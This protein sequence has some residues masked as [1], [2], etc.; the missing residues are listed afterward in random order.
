MVPDKTTLHV[1][2]DGITLD[3]ERGTTILTAAR[4]AGVEI[5][6]LCWHPKVSIMGACRVCLVEV[7][8]LN[9]LIAA[10]HTPVAE[11]MVV[12]TATP[13][14]RKLR[15]TLFELLLARHPRDCWGCDKGGWCDLQA[16][17]FK[18]GP[19]RHRFE[20]PS[21]ASRVEDRS[22]FVER[23]TRKCVMC[24]RCIR[25]C[26]EVRGTSVWG[27]MY[28]GFDKKICTFFEFPLGSDFHD[29]FNCEFCGSC[30]DICPVG[31][32]TAKPSKYK[33]RPWEVETA[34][35]SCPFCG[36]GCRMTAHHRRGTLVKTTP[37]K[38]PDGNHSD[39]CFRG[40]FGTIHAAHPSRL[41]ETRMGRDGE[42]KAISPEKAAAAL[43]AVLAAAGTPGAAFVGAQSTEEETAALA[44]LMASGSVHHPVFVL[45]SRGEAEAGEPAWP[46]G[47]R[48]ATVDELATAGR[49][50][51]IGHDFT[52]HH[53][54][55]GVR[56]RK[57]LQAGGS[58]LLVDPLDTLLGRQAAAWLRVPPSSQAALVEQFRDE[59]A[60]ACGASALAG[61][62][63]LVPGGGGEAGGKA[64]EWL[65][66][67]GPLTV[68]IQ[69]IPVQA[70]AVNG[71]A[72]RLLEAAG[73]GSVVYLTPDANAFGASV[74]VRGVGPA[75][76]ERALEDLL[77]SDRRVPAVF[78][79]RADPLGESARPEL[80]EALRRRS[81]TWVVFDSFLTRTAAR[82]DLV[83]PVPLFTE[84]AGSIRAAGGPGS[85][86][87][88][89]QPPPSVRDM[90][91]WAGSAATALGKGLAWDG[92]A[93]GLDD[94]RARGRR[95]GQAPPAPVAPAAICRGGES[96]WLFARF[97]R[98]PGHR[99]ELAEARAV[100]GP[101]ECLEVHPADAGAMGLLDGERVTV[102]ASG[103]SAAFAVRVTPRTPPG[104]L[105]LP[106]DP[107]FGDVI[108]FMSALGPG[109]VS[110]G[111]AVSVR[112]G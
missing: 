14:I 91:S 29:P 75:A 49:I 84:N 66:G 90:L 108:R 67:E 36:V 70:P 110:G 6:T 94:I 17:A 15:Q 105:C 71:A 51:L 63:D 9:K 47:I 54:V 112:K 55:A 77:A 4:E 86:T 42:G 34:E 22:P 13:L 81:T 23:D 74:I 45:D 82:A 102:E 26:R 97:H 107:S 39:L 100:I 25:V 28:R 72:A 88:L 76:D 5:P 16:L 46:S 20:L 85:F 89:Y 62:L 33:T 3:V 58:L 56:I 68:V 57:A 11:G 69:K 109:F 24:R 53:P 101:Q 37:V 32:L 65:K 50:I 78:F 60:S 61:F 73:G 18:F 27:A 44:S 103:A 19:E 43:A 104:C 96:F 92:G 35:T 87:R 80:W 12:R 52:F 2:I 48:S 40:R 95:V 8:G 98:F 93:A 99:L 31:A 21:P 79:L 106:F 38:Y 41:T 30:I 1:T 7:E 111:A 83:V 64:T 59:L 10:C